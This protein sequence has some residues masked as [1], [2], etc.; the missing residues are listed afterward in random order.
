MKQNNTKYI[1]IGIGVGILFCDI[2]IYAYQYPVIV[3]IGWG[4]FALAL[5]L[6]FIWLALAVLLI[7][8]GYLQGSKNEEDQFS[9][10]AQFSVGWVGFLLISFALTLTIFYIGITCPEASLPMMRGES[11]CSK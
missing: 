1:A 5:F 6:Q 8:N 7:V 4:K 2:A 3:G 9:Y 10:R 11:I